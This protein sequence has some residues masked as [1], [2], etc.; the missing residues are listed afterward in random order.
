MRNTCELIDFSRVLVFM[1]SL[2][3]LLVC[4]LFYRYFSKLLILFFSI[5]GRWTGIWMEKLAV[6]IDGR[7]SNKEL[8]EPSSSKWKKPSQPDIRKSI[9][10]SAKGVYLKMM[11]TA[12]EMA[13]TPSTPHKHFSVLVKCQRINGVCL[14][15]GKDNNK[16]GQWILRKDVSI[17]KL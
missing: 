12:W 11:K 5:L 6:L 17:I 4:K 16:A 14:V 3:S 13:L 9:D 10:S 7:T 1:L 8:G 15:A 2:L